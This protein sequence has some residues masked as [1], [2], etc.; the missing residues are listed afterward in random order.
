M[1]F[2]SV[3]R[4]AVREA[5]PTLRVDTARTLVSMVDDA[6]RR[7]RLLAWLGGAF[8]GLALILAA[9][10]LYGV[11]AY[12]AARRTPEMGIRLA[13]GAN[14]FQI[15]ALLLRE[16]TV[17]LA[18]GLVLG[19]GATVLFTRWLDSLLFDLTPQDPATLAFAA[20]LLSAVAIAAGY[21]PAR[22]AARL[23][24][25]TALRAE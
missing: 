23:D 8:G 13:L 12:T 21:F 9:V 24:P 14:P 10:G 3:V 6:T 5:A 15:R 19:W 22:R 11:I 17:L 4:Q 16:F 1:Q 20:A 25:M 7:E 18:I 2:A